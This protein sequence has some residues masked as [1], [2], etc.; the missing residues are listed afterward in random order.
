MYNPCRQ[1]CFIQSLEHIYSILIDFSL[2]NHLA[3]AILAFKHGLSLLC[4]IIRG[5]DNLKTTF[6]SLN[7][8]F[9]AKDALWNIKDSSSLF[10]VCASIS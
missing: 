10:T 1:G 6:L 5:F 8:A 4:G 2:R 7:F 3:Y 9:W